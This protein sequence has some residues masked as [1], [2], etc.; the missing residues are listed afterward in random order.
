MKDRKIAYRNSWLAENLNC[1][2]IQLAPLSNLWE[3]AWKI[4]NN[5][6]NKNQLQTNDSHCEFDSIETQDSA[7]LLP[8]GIEMQ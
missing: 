6:Y 4:N 7:V 2:F 8:I 3:I 5:Q 1:E